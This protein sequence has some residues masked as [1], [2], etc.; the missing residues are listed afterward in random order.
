MIDI[1]ELIDD[2][3]SDIVEYEDHGIGYYEYGDGKYVDEN[4]ILS[5]TDSEVMVQYLTQEQD[6]YIPTTL[7][8]TIYEEDD[9]LSYTAYLISVEICSGGY[10]IRYEVEKNV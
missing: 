10:K 4:V 8:G 1:E 2:A 3:V 7:S 6:D 9:Q 5:L